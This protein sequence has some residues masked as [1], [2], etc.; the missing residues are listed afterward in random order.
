[1]ELNGLKIT[2]LK[3]RLRENNLPVSG[4]KK[5]LINRLCNIIYSPAEPSPP[6]D[7]FHDIPEIETNDQEPS[8]SSQSA[9]TDMESVLNVLRAEQRA[10]MDDFRK[11]FMDTLQSFVQATLQP[12]SQSSPLP[13]NQSAQQTRTSSTKEN[14]PQTAQQNRITA[15]QARTPS[16]PEVSEIEAQQSR[17]TN[18]LETS[19]PAQ[20][21]RIIPLLPDNSPSVQAQQPPP[22]SSRES[23][24]IDSPTHPQFSNS[25]SDQCIAPIEV[26]SSVWERDVHFSQLSQYRNNRQA[27]LQAAEAMP[28]F[29]PDNSS[30][31]IK[32]AR[33]FVSRIRALQEH[34]GWDD[35]TVLEAAQQKLRGHAKLWNDESPDVY[36]T[37]SE[38][39]TDIL[40]AFPTYT[41]NADVLEE[42]LVQKRRPNEGIE[43]FC[44]RMIVLGRRA[45][46]S[47][48]DLAQY[49]IKRINHTQFVTSIGCVRIRSVG[50]LLQAVAYFT[51]KMPTKTTAE[52]QHTAGGDGSSNR[53]R[54]Q[55]QSGIGRNHHNNH[56]SNHQTHQTSQRD[57]TETTTTTNKTNSSHRSDN[58]ANKCWNC[59]SFGHSL[60]QCKA[61][62]IK[63]A[64]CQ[65]IGH[66]AEECRSESRPPR[67]VMRID[68]D[69]QDRVDFSKRIRIN[70]IEATAF[71]D[72]GSR[73]SLISRTFS[74]RLQ[75]TVPTAPINV[76]GFTGEPI[77]CSELVPATISIEGQEYT[78]EL[79]VVDDDHLECEDVLLGTDILCGVGRFILI[80][81]NTC[82]IVPSLS[83][84]A[85]AN[86][87]HAS[88]LID[89]FAQCFAESLSKIGKAS[90][91]ALEIK[92][93]TQQPFNQR[94][95]R[96]PFAKRPGVTEMTNELLKNDIIEHSNSPY[97]SQLVIVKK[98]NGEDRLCVDYRQLN[99]VT[100]RQPY[101]MPVI[102]E[103]LANLA[104]HKYFTI[105]DF[106]SGY[107]QVSVQED[108]R[109]YTAFDTHDGHFQFKRMPFGLVNAPFLF[110]SCI[111]DLIKQM[112]PGEAMAYLD[113]VIIP[114]KTIEDGLQRLR[115]FF[116]II[117]ES[118]LTLRLSKCVFL[119]ECVKYLG[120][121]ISM[122]IIEPGDDKIAAIR[123]FPQP[124]NAQ[125]TRRFLG[126]SG[127]FRKFVENYSLITKPLTELLKT[128]N[129]PPFVWG[130]EQMTAFNTLKEH[131]CQAPILRLYDSKQEHEVHTD[132]S[133]VG[134]AGVL[135][136]KAEDGKFYPV[137]YFSRH[138]SPAER[139]YA[140]H[141][142]EV[143]AMVE[144]LERNRVC[145]LGK[146]FR[147]VTDCSAITTTKNS[148]PLAPR[149]ARWWLRLQEFDF[150]LVH[151]PGT[152]LEYVDALS[153]APVEPPQE[154]ISVAERLMRVSVTELDWLVTMQQQDQNL[155]QIMSTLRSDERNETLSQ[156]Q[157]DYELKNHRLF[158]KVDGHLRWVVPS[159]VR[160]RILKSAHDDRGH[161]G[162]EKTLQYIQESFWFP[163]MRNFTKNYLL[164]CIEC[165]YHKRPGGKTEGQLHVSKTIPTPFRTLHIDHLGPFPRSTRGN[166]YVLAIVDS[167]SKYVTVKAVRTTNTHAVTTTLS[168]LSK[169]FGVPERIVSDRG[170]AF[171]S[172]SFAEYCESNAIEHIQNAVRT[173]RANGQVERINQ[174]ITTFLRTSESDERKWDTDLGRFQVII[175]SQVNKTIS[176]S[177]NDIIFRFKLRNTTDNKLVAALHDPDSWDEE[178]LLPLSEVARIA[179]EEKQKWKARYDK[180]HSSPTKYAENDLVLVENQPPATGESRKLEPR[181]RGPYVVKRVLDCDRY[182]VADLKDIQR[183]QRYFE[184]VFASDKMKPWCALG[185][186]ADEADELNDGAE[187][188]TTSGTAEAVSHS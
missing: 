51:Q 46:I 184:S 1:M 172:K 173:P 146:H 65:R 133:S 115:R 188:D 149:I 127:F 121:K 56:H 104:G 18:H 61:E 67:R 165:A 180:R 68:G 32:S 101:P 159:A 152:Q 26:R 50:E 185:P 76:K 129:S 2:E 72:G 136:Q 153:R 119:A 38:F 47:D 78:G 85:E 135:M 116:I 81:E 147:V 187:D 64:N 151:R 182:L 17:T 14:S 37:F 28:D 138:C 87:S 19:I 41:T 58:R 166:A 112:P 94:G 186:T 164:A 177:P 171:T 178:D 3:E 128:V 33:A 143:L 161:F 145:L 96:I 154:A 120:H 122:N 83:E 107:Y 139:N 82:K 21:I 10:Q 137:S 106:M 157:T 75:K 144:T 97:S 179:D 109:K 89:E 45:R 6:S 92:L 84:Y 99:A 4:D 79:Y 52:Q 69:D 60:P 100:V 175:N 11:E 35:F 30:G 48:E 124:T 16:M 43:E 150:D 34:Y 7:Q 162:L 169:F 114:S 15:Q 90:Q 77:Q 54:D 110:Q 108:S 183:N 142:L 130:P 131:L 27:V 22:D 57:A 44:R 126:L 155:S 160:W 105:L 55:Q 168:E 63:C 117:K 111:N 91:V 29:D 13:T 12:Q 93:T 40:A 113:D 59:K 174:L 103:L 70:D 53:V 39:E 88:Q 98:A 31:K 66:N 167:F 134:L 25:T 80:G 118:G 36:R 140:S 148:K 74:Q 49:I 24:S 141:E 95:C 20:Q 170:T 176:C 8:G 123:D 5:T 71:I 158:R 62:I 125:E 73:L 163:R 181:Y 102:D 9:P 86:R 23:H 42:I 156:L 132:A